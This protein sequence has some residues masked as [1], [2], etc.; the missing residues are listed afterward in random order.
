MTRRL[1]AA[2]LTDRG[3][4]REENQDSF[5]ALEDL[6]LFAVADGMG[7]HAAGGVASRMAIEHLSRAVAA[8]AGVADLDAAVRLLR[9][10]ALGA[11]RAIRERAEREPEKRDMGTTFTALLFPSSA[12]GF[13]IA[14]VGDSRAYRLRGE[15]LTRLT[16]DH[17]WVQRQ[18]DMGL[19]SRSR[20]ARHP[21]RNVLDQALGIPGGIEVD[22]AR[23]DIQPGDTFVICSDGLTEL[24]KEDDLKA[25]LGREEPLDRIA[26]QAVEA[27]N[28]R[29]GIDNIT[30][31]LIRAA[32]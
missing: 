17:T 21:H 8:D 22:T 27:A 4:E 30:L 15:E 28:L 26:R 2:G 7:G 23:E 3:R 5:L 10:A 16:T 9:E 14:H 19:L 11:H 20:A 31:I 29:G 12:S 24:V 25:L 6:G 13:A 18:I 1:E 32:A